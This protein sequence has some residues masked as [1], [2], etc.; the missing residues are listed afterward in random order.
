MIFQLSK[1]RELVYT[2]QLNPPIAGRAD[3]TRAEPTLTADRK[4][5][6][7]FNPPIAGRADATSVGH[8]ER[9]IRIGLSTRPLLRGLMRP[10]FL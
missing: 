8:F 2:F 10:A 1:G 3:A 4:L 7:S 5:T 9:G 6:R